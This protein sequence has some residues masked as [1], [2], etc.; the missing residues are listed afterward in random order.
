MAVLNIDDSSFGHLGRMGFGGVLRDG[1]GNW[2]LGIYGHLGFSDCLKEEL[3]GLLHGLDM[4]WSKGI[5]DLVCYS[6]SQTRLALVTGRTP[7]FHSY[8][9]LIK[10]IKERLSR[11]WRIRLMHTWREGNS[12]ADLLA[13]TGARFD[14]RY[15]W[16]FRRRKS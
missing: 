16:W 6:D 14:R 2:I 7:D 9:G 15:T 13:K 4:A 10:E 11:N 12:S 3:A 5:S 8:L 1:E